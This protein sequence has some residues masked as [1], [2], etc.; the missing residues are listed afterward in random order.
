MHIRTHA[1]N[2]GVLLLLLVHILFFA[3]LGM[4][5]FESTPER[6]EFADLLSSLMS[7]VVLLTTVSE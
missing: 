6:P 2:T 7:L 1:T 5:C 3:T 4:I